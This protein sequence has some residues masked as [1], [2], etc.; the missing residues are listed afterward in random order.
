[1]VFLFI[2]LILAITNLKVVYAERPSALYTSKSQMIA[3]WV[4]LCDAHPEWASYESI[5]KSIQGNDIWLFKIGTPTGGR[6]MY[7]GQCHGSEDGGTEILYKF[8]EWLLESNDTLAKHILQYNYHLIIPILNVDTTARQNMRREYVLDNGTV[9]NVPY[10]VDLNRNGVYRWG[11]SG[12]PDPNNDYEYRGLYGG[13]E[14]ETMALHNAVGKYRPEIYVNTHNGGEYMLHYLNTSLEAKIKTL[15]AQ[16]EQEYNI[17]NPYPARRGGRGGFLS[18][19]AAGSWNASGWLWEVTTWENLTPTLDE[20]LLKYYPRAFPVLL[21]FAKAVE[22]EPPPIPEITL[23][24]ANINAM[25]IITISLLTLILKF[26]IQKPPK[27]QQN[28]IQ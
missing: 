7:D 3:Q 27:N 19:D 17:T 10:G 4:A 5:G 9:I 2:T 11:E 28:S 12:S 25:L 15:K 21:A 23:Q 20:W 8:C 16:Y 24:P 22:K 6:V 14:P 1:M 18:A 26:K 13:S